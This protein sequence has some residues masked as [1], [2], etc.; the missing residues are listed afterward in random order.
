MNRISQSL[1]LI[2]MAVTAPVWAV[3]VPEN[4]SA[5]PPESAA[6]PSNQY[7]AANATAGS[8]LYGLGILQNNLAAA[9]VGDGTTTDQTAG[10]EIYTSFADVAV[11]LNDVLVRYTYM[12]DADLGGTVPANN[13]RSPTAF[14]SYLKAEIAR[15]SPILKAANTSN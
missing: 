10:N 1:V 8:V 12:G 7:V 11:G 15:W 13:E 4:T 5:Q 6:A 2:G 3:S 14:A 9:N